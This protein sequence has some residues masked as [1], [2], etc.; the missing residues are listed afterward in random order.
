ML[1]D[2]FV[3]VAPEAHQTND[4]GAEVE[5]VAATG[6]I[7]FQ[8]AVYQFIVDEVVRNEGNEEFLRFLLS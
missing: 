1:K 3:L 5:Q 4:G 8:Q 6:Q 2:H 7:E